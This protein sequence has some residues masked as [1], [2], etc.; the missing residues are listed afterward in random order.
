MWVPMRCSESWK[1]GIG[2]TGVVPC[3][4]LARLNFCSDS[5]TSRLNNDAAGAS[6]AAGWILAVLGA[7][8]MGGG[9]IA[10]SPTAR[11]VE[12]L[13]ITNLRVSRRPWLEPQDRDF[14]WAE[15]V[16]SDGRYVAFSS[17]STRVRR[18]DTFPHQ[19]VYV[20]DVWRR[21]T[22]R[23]SVGL[24]GRPSDDRAR[25]GGMSG[26]GRVVVFASRASNL[27]DGDENGVD[28]VFCHDQKSRLTW[29]ISESESGVDSNRGAGLGEQRCISSDGRRVA[30]Q[31]LSTN[32][33][34]ADGP[35][36]YA[37]VYLADIG[38]GVLDLISRSL[39]GGRPD[40]WSDCAS[41][42]A[43]GRFVTYVSAASNIV[44][45]DDNG[46]PDVFVWDAT[47][48]ETRR[49]PVVLGVEGGGGSPYNPTIDDGGSCVAFSY[50]HDELV[51][52]QES[53]VPHAYVY[54]VA[55]GE[56]RVLLGPHSEPIPCG[57]VCV[58]ADGNEVVYSSSA[59]GLVPGDDNGMQDVF[60]LTLDSGETRVLSVDENGLKGNG[61][62]FLGGSP[63]SPDGEWCVFA[64]A[65]TNWNRRD[66]NFQGTDVFRV[67]VR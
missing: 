17:A 22:R 50:T 8:A 46:L 11:D 29:R 3:S 62:S 13:R 39:D 37:Q 12:F 4:R 67:R 27:V 30:F 6:L 60:V 1:A 32:L 5:S 56:A 35:E 41:I 57:Y 43:N 40:G 34:V 26:D 59:D 51:S 2:G 38:S 55:A 58:S 10:A 25:F 24:R 31:S 53:L 49:I 48:R 20:R 36:D 64:S 9:V 45:G 23:V 52:G 33:V 42:S 7:M 19:Q 18:G 21:R 65:A 47:T 54:E 15:G 66:R 16:S 28:D 44:E 61:H 14:A 63:L